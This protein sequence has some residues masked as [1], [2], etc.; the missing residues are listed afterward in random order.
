M[1]TSGTIDIQKECQLYSRSIQNAL[2]DILNVNVTATTD[3]ERVS[4]LEEEDN[5]FFSILITGQIYGEFLFGLNKKTALKML[6]IGIEDDKQAYI[7]NRLDVLDA[8]KEVINIAAGKTLAELKNVFPDLSITP[9]KAVEGHITLPNYEMARTYLHHLSGRLSCYIY[10]DYM[11]LDVATLLEKDKELLK[12]SN[13]KQEELKRL[14]KAKSEFL[15]N[16]SHELRTPLNGM[17]GMLDILKTSK[18]SSVQMEQFDIIYR[19]GEFLLS[20]ISDILEFSKIESGKLETENKKFNLRDAIESVTESLSSMIFGKGLDFNVYINPTIA[21]EYLGDQTR[22]KQVLMNLLGNATKFTPSGSIYVDVDVSEDQ[23]I[24]IKVTDTGIG[25]PADKIDTLFSSFSQVDVSDVRKYGG[26]GLG[27]AISKSIIEAMGGS[28]QVKSEE[29]KG[30]EFTLKIPFEIVPGSSG[31]EKVIPKNNFKIIGAGPAVVHTLS[32]YLISHAKN[33]EINIMSISEDI[34]LQENDILFIDLKFWQKL[35]RDLILKFVEKVK[36]ANTYVVFLTL[37][38]ELEVVQAIAREHDWG[39]IYFLNRPIEYKRIISLLKKNTYLSLRQ[40][41]DVKKVLSAQENRKVLVVEDNKVNQVVVT[42]M[43]MKLGYE[44]DVVG[45]GQQAFN[46]ISKGS[47][48]YFI[49]MDCQMPVMSGYDATRAIRKLEEVGQ[50]HIPIIALTANAFR[51]TKENCF[52]CGMDD[53]ATKPIKLETL[54]EVV[55]RTLE[56]LNKNGK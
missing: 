44:A 6:G 38:R 23:Q 21:N 36:R 11:K 53:F 47:S 52:E 42:T 3:A 29:A 24:V 46:L 49:L 25:I 35:E 56:K 26:T 18:L 19:S 31:D 33:C 50:A 34:L 37:P 7:Q 20:L 28:I 45:D 8:F 5:L 48:Y 41:E 15:A 10:I 2:H 12:I 13:E 43:L 16:M 14:N 32:K 30:S 39:R 40:A 22:L 9:P 55:S 17:I 51:E 27:L 54:K 1:K 4:Q